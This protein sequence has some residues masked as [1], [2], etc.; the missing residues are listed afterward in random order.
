MV[1]GQESRG[2]ILGRVSDLSGA[3]IPGATVKITNTATGVNTPGAT[4]EQGNYF[5]PYLIPGLYRIDIEHRGFKRV[6]RDGIE[7]RVNDRLEINLTLEVGEV[8]EQITVVAETPLLETATASMGSVVDSRR[9]AEL[10]VPH[11]NPYILIQL[12]SGVAF[13]QSLTLDRP[14]EPTHIVGYTMDGARSNRSE[15]TLDGVPNTASG[16]TGTRNEVISSW[17]PPADTVSEFKVQT[18]PFDASVG[19]TE[20]GVINVSLK[21]GTN[22]FHGTA[23]YVKMAP[24]LTANLFFS[25]R[26]QIPRGNF[27]YNRW[28]TMATGP[29]IFPKL[30]DGRNRT[31]YMY[32]YEG[33]H[34]ERPR[35]TT[36]TVPTAKQREGD[37]SD[38]LKLGSQYQIYDPATRRTAPGGRFQSD[39]LPGNIVP[40]GRISPVAKKMLGYYA[41][42]TVPGTA[43]GRNNL[44]MPHEPEVITYYTHTFRLDHNLS[45][46]HRIFSRV[47]VYKRESDY[48]NWFKSAATGQWF[49]FLSRG[50]AFD[51][52]YSFSP[53]FVMN[54]R[55]GYN[56]FIRVTDSNPAGRGFD[57]TTL[58]LPASYNNAIDAKIRRF[59]VISID[60]Y[61]GTYNG[62][63]WR[64]TETH[65][66]T[67]AFDK[68]Q[69]THS[70]KFGMEYRAYRENQYEYDN[71]STGSFDFGTTWTRGPLD[72]SP[73]APIGQGLATMLLGLP[74]GGF[75]DRRASYAEQS[76]AWSL[77]LQDD[78]KLTRRLSVTLGLRYEIEGPLTERFNR[79][80]RGLDYNAALPLEAQV[81][82]NYAKS[83]TPEVPPDQFRVRGGL[84]FAALGGL[85]RTLWERDA[86]NFMPRIGF[87]YTA[88]PKIVVRGGYG[89]FFGFLGT[90]RGDIIQTGF[91]Q[92][93]SLIPSL[94]GGLTFVA[95]L[96]N[97]FPSGIQEP[98]GA[99]LGTMTYVGQGISFINTKPLAPYMQ[100]WQFSVQREL[101]HRIVAEVSYVGNRG[102]K[103]ETGRNLNAF[104]VQYLSRTGVRD[105]PVIDYFS[106]NL[107][108]PY[109]PL[110]PGT[111]RAGTLISRGTLITAYPHFGGLSTTTNEG[112]SW[113]HSFQTKVDKRFSAGYT[114]GVA[115]TW[116][117]FMEATGFLND[118]DPVPAKVISDQDYP[119]RLSLSWI[120]ELPFGRGR[121]LLSQTNPVA[122]AILSGW[123]VQGLYAAQSGQAFGFGNVIFR[124][125]LKDIV[126]PKSQRT[127]EQWFN[128]NAGFE[129]DSAKQLSYAARVMSLRFSG[130]RGDGIN[131]WDLSVIKDTR[132]REGMKAQ[133]RAEF[134]NAFNHVLFSNPNTS[135]TSTAFGAITSEK[136]YPRR[137]QLGIKFIY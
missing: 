37:F 72:N 84:T 73:A 118:G 88:T 102:T 15:V 18:A 123:Q 53:T 89:V 49:Q 135:V 131:N 95:T 25:N 2:S 127:P 106:A 129:R 54:L 40:A 79:S 119:H 104:P 30:M 17:V 22:A 108:N 113:Y 105:Q 99:A 93:T 66:F 78:W 85:P 26:N 12:A 16:N 134:L 13:A 70:L 114:V 24:E 75:V 4:N 32:G 43:D 121:K 112:Y 6:V 63:L 48:N 86:N 1:F 44:P 34:E 42:P 52:V 31:F 130:I 94:D 116:A 23:Y 109:Y 80:I 83:P 68:V 41:L 137:I 100:R 103:I 136:G 77:Y 11:G 101:P 91:S 87:A 117:K 64:P 71:V 51:D 39:P 56:R 59:P 7:L 120:W 81:K 5:A 124:G 19:Q 9:V 21:S 55:Y 133:F 76:T 36:L 82:A 38:L 29:V 8:T 69:G 3:V 98:R 14:F 28:G 58:G 97:P 60:G 111:G 115:Y 27:T 107:P 126:L 92:T 122:S 50:A 110:L 45:E 125:N 90:R 57:L 62:W 47:N 128:I 96:A 61:S 65:S 132:I 20:G 67:G 35:G 33:I 46:R 74:T 10:P